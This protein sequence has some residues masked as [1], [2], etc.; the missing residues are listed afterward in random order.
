LAIENTQLLD[1]FPNQKPPCIGDFPAIFDDQK[2]NPI[3]SLLNPIYRKGKTPFLGVCSSATFDS[4]MVKLCKKK[5]GGVQRSFCMSEHSLVSS[6]MAL[7]LGLKKPV[8]QGGAPL[9]VTCLVEDSAN[10][11]CGI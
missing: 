10:Q 2:E 9:N 1:V 7:R 11:K 3:K 8:R 4:W 6:A 5:N